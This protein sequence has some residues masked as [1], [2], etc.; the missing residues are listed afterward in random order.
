MK[1]NFKNPKTG[2][3]FYFPTFCT[4]YRDGKKIY[5][6]KL[7]RNEISDPKT[8]DTLEHIEVPFEGFKDGP[9][10]FLGSEAG[11]LANCRKELRKTN[12]A[13]A[14]SEDFKRT[15]ERNDEIEW[16]NMGYSKDK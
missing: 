14:N 15:M 6:D 10:V 1:N 12:E 8:G 16:N 4:M 13:H 2:E 7:R 11:R 9:P 3:E 5:T